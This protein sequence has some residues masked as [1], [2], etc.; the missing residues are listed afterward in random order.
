MDS[1]QL[2][3]AISGWT[4]KIQHTCT[5]YNV[6]LRIARKTSKFRP[7]YFTIQFWTDFYENE[8]KK[9]SR[10]KNS[11]WPIFQNHRFSKSPILKKI[12]QQFHRLG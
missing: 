10:K 2:K 12:L 9:K 3:S 1:S 6:I 5:L 11:K 4:F 8:A 7:I